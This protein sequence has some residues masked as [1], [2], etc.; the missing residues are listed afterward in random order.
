[1]K[2]QS[3]SRVVSKDSL[4]E[5]YLGALAQHPI[6]GQHILLG[7]PCRGNWIRDR[8]VING[9]DAEPQYE[10]RRASQT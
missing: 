3:D 2:I 9:R 6:L 1:M 7:D 5:D 4:L 10:K 8:I